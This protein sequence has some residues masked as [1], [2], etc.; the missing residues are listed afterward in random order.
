MHGV[1]NRRAEAGCAALQ[2]LDRRLVRV[3]ERVEESFPD[4]P[5]VQLADMLAAG[6]PPG[7]GLKPPLACKPIAAESRQASGIPWGCL[8]VWH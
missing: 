6:E 7:Q 1:G 2:Y 3:P 8:E 5:H 4:L